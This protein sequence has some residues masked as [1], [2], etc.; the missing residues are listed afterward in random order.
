M[1]HGLTNLNVQIGGVSQLS[2]NARY[3]YEMFNE[4]FAGVNAING[5]QTDGLTSGLISERSWSQKHGYIY[6]QVNR[7]TELEKSSPKSVQIQFQN[8]AAKKIDYFVFITYETSVSS[9]EGLG[10]LQS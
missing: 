7:G 1:L 9:D 2:Q 5:G 3:G 8:L 10:I 6:L 4:Q